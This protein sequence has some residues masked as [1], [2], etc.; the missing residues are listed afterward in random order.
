MY[1]FLSSSFVSYEERYLA[2]SVYIG[3][4]I[5]MLSACPIVFLLKSE[6]IE[7]TNYLDKKCAEIDN[8]MIRK[9]Q[10]ISKLETYKKSLIFE[11]VTGKKEV[12]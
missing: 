6:Q 12:K 10:L 1:Y 11:Y 9:E 5:E 2:G 4:N 7:I 3:L 8:L